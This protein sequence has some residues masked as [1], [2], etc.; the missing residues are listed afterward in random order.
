MANAYTIDKLD[1]KTKKALV[2]DILSGL[3]D[4]KIADNYGL[5]KNCV[6]RYKNDK[7]VQAVAEVWAEQKKESAS[8][9]A[10]QFSAIATRL[11]KA[12][13]AID[14]ELTD[15]N[16]DYDLSNAERAY[17][18]IKMLN[19]TSRSLQNNI[20]GLAKITGDMKEIAETNSR[21]TLIV[22]QIIQIIQ[23]L[24]IKDREVIL[25]RLRVIADS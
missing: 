17:P 5:P 8:E 14:K 21:P 6:T 12:L 7:L 22:T 3:P 10:E 23:T 20:M 18:Y 16:G 11:N 9:Y 1:P 19:D 25:D 4:N 2:K 24:D 15:S 13:D